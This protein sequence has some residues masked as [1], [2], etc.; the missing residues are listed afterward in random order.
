MVESVFAEEESTPFAMNQETE[1]PSL[2]RDLYE[3][4]AVNLD[5]DQKVTQ[6]EVI[7]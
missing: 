6:K 3:H 5:D 4:G 7:V 2:V 1:V